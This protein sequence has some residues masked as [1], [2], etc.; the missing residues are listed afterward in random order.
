MDVYVFKLQWPQNIFSN[1]N[2]LLLTELLT[3]VIITFS[4]CFWILVKVVQIK[5]LLIVM[6][7][8]SYSTK[9]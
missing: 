7:I 6:I 5:L 2:D 4:I 9:D 8:L 1:N 3:I